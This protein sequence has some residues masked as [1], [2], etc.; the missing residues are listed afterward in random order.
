MLAYGRI[1]KNSRNTQDLTQVELAQKCFTCREQ[2]IAIENGKTPPSSNFREIFANTLSNPVLEYFP[3]YSIGQFPKKARVRFQH[4]KEAAIY[5]LKKLQQQDLDGFQEIYSL[6][7][8]ACAQKDANLMIVLDEYVHIRIMNDHPSHP[9][10][11]LVRRY[12]QD[13]MD[14]FK[15]WVSELDFDMTLGR[16]TMHFKIFEAILE[17]NERRLIE[18]IDRHLEN[19]LEDM[20]RFTKFL[21]QRVKLK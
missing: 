1:L 20:E 21:K 10:I 14:F 7:K 4:E 11:S 17:Q 13:Y 15:V 18:A 3:P 2:I 6:Y 16:V 19:A 12:R 9:V 8:L 5:F